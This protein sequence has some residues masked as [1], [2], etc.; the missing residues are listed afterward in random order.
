M[1]RTIEVESRYRI[2]GAIPK[3]A[4]SFSSAQ[5]VVDIYLDT[6]AGAFYQQGVYI[7]NRNN[8]KLDFKFNLESFLDPT[9]IND[10]SHCDEYSY[11][12]PFNNEAKNDF[13]KVCA[14]LKLRSPQNFTYAEFLKI[15]SLV[16]LVT[17]DKQ[18]SKA[19]DA[20]FELCLDVIKGAGNFIEIEKLVEVPQTS[21]EDQ[22][23][24]DKI[25]QNMQTYIES[26][27]IKAER[28]ES[29]YVELILQKTNNELYKQGR[30]LL[31]KDK[32]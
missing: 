4:L 29:G 28:F 31:D 5:R 12:I 2:I 30:Y 11:N 25:K 20:G 10:H 16:P 26:L 3:L 18:R 27:G 15:N 9:F 6:Q 1:N 17:I 13:D 8:F 24:L 22:P 7:R 32:T 14:I 23:N 21:S 19:K